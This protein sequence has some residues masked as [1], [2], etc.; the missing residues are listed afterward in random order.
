M[1]SFLSKNRHSSRNRSSAVSLIPPAHCD[2]RA[3]VVRWDILGLFELVADTSP[4]YGTVIIQSVTD[5]SII[6]ITA[7][8]ASQ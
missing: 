1:Q 6:A 5:A 8:T 3:G 2:V 7:P 4:R